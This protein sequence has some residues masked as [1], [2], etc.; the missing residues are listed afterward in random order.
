MTAKYVFISYGMGGAGIEYWDSG[1][2]QLV[3]RCRALGYDTFGS[4]YNWSDVNAI[5]SEINQAPA[6]A[7][8]AVGGASLGSNEAPDI[9]DRTKRRIKYLF[10]F[11]TSV[12]GYRTGIP[13]NVE[14]ADNIYNPSWLQTFGL[15]YGKWYPDPGNV[16]TIIRNIPIYA[17]HPD[18]WGA[19]Q[20][21]IYSQIHKWMG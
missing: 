1:L 15:G 19:A 12:W 16:R 21:I 8:I 14:R 13:A 7:L 3:K 4:P 9:A 20:D 17:P 10:G 6:D 18:D 5:V 11:Q 2:R